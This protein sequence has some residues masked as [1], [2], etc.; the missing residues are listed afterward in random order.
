MDLHCV[1]TCR[2]GLFPAALQLPPGTGPPRSQR[3]V[4][5]PTKQETGW[6]AAV[7]S[8]ALGVS[9]L[10]A[11]HRVLLLPLPLLHHGLQSQLTRGTEVPV[12]FGQEACFLLTASFWH[13]RGG[14]KTKQNKN[15]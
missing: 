13:P 15:L 12:P 3:P 7:C 5:I 4:V 11:Q 8:P 6:E 10:L 2:E 14:K 9:G 1:P